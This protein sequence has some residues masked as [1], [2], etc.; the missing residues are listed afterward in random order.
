MNVCY[1]L[2]GVSGAGKSTYRKHLLNTHMFDASVYSLD[3]FRQEFAKIHDPSRVGNAAA[4]FE[5][6]CNND[7]I[8]NKFVDEKF[9][10]VVKSPVIINDN[11]NQTVKARR[12]FYEKVK[13]THKVVAVLINADL[14]TIL[15]RQKHRGAARVS[16]GVVKDMFFRMQSVLI[17]EDCDIII[18]L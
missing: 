3:D 4:C 2:V 1:M 5:L 8:F 11:T 14:D 15:E 6:A 9:K 7:K 16:D 12:A 18:S 13:A 10:E 17:G